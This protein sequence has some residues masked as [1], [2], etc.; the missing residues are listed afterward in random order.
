MMV[1]A[2]T[3][4]II[5]NETLTTTYYGQMKMQRRGDD[6]DENA[7]NAACNISLSGTDLD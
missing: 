2:S 4:M 7:D 3:V 6:G 1:K 5:A